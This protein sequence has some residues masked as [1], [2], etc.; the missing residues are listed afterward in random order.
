MDCPAIVCE[1]WTTPNNSIGWEVTQDVWG[2]A[3]DAWGATTDL[4]GDGVGL[5]GNILSSEGAGT[6]LEELFERVTIKR[7]SER[8]PGSEE[9]HVE[10]RDENGQLIDPEGNPVPKRDPGNHTPIEWDLPCW[11]TLFPSD[12]PSKSC[13][14]NRI[15]CMRPP[16]RTNSIA[17]GIASSSSVP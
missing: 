5:L 10:L 17:I 1:G 7:G 12:S 13:F 9:P 2:E 14:A 3:E 16:D 8:T 15:H 4:G 11:L 6:S